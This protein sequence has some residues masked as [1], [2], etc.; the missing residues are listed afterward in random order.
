MA[1]S[2]R[3]FNVDC[4]IMV[5]KDVMENCNAIGIPI[6][7][8]FPALLKENTASSLEALITCGYFFII[9][10]A[11]NTADTACAITVAHAT[12]ATPIW[13]LTTNTKSS[14]IFNA[15][16]KIKKYNGVLLSPTA[17]KIAANKL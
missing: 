16:D 9:Y 14:R 10:P 1:V 17:L 3:R 5:P 2:P 7:I 12:P 6:P 4:T 8:S 11:H 13:K 15:D